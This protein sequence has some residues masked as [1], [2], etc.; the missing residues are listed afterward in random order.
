MEASLDIG[1]VLEA[2]LEGPTVKYTISDRS[3]LLYAQCLGPYAQC[4]ASV[5]ASMPSVLGS[6]QSVLRLLRTDFCWSECLA[7]YF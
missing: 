3:G 5:L 2:L 7:L 4:L 1:E 6:M